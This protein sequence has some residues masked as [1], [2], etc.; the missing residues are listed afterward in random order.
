AG[1]GRVEGLS[2]F[3]GD[4]VDGGT[5]P[6]GEGFA[7]QPDPPGTLLLAGLS[8]EVFES[9]RVDSVGCH[10]QPV[11]ARLPLNQTWG[12]RLAQ[13]GGQALQGIRRVG[14]RTLTPNPVDE[15]R[16][17]DNVTWFERGRDQQ[18]AQPGARHL[19]DDA[20]VRANLERSKQPDLHLADFATGDWRASHCVGGNLAHAIIALHVQDNRT[21]GSEYLAVYTRSRSGPADRSHRDRGGADGSLRRAG[22]RGE[23][24]AGR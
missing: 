6:Q 20:V 7:Q 12:Q 16:L 23:P 1:E 10:R 5:A 9:Q 13:P 22:H 18:P 17:P 24:F 14:G 8:Q 2:V 11:A 19:G 4:I 3:E 21:G 15:R